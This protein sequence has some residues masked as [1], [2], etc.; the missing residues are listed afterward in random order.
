MQ[1]TILIVAA[2]PQ[3]FLKRLK[4]D[5]CF[6]ICI[7]FQPQ[8]LSLEVGAERIPTLVLVACWGFVF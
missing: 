1:I 3:Q 7:I 8:P 2:K 6:P 5:F 4:K